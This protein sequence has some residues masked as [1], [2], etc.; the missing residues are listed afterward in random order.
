MKESSLLTYIVG[1][2]LAFLAVLV[3]EALVFPDFLG[4]SLVP[5]GLFA[6]AVWL[7]TY[8]ASRKKHTQAM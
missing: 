3:V 6:V 2:L 1:I 8:R 5:V 7:N 4:I